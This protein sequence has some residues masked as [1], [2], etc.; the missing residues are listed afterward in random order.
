MVYFLYLRQINNKTNMK[1][2]SKFLSLCALAI[3]LTFTACK[4]DKVVELPAENLATYTGDLSYAGGANTIAETDGKATVSQSGKIVSISFN[5]GVPS[6][7]S[8]QFEKSGSNYVSIT[9][10]GSVAGISFS[11]NTVSIAYTKDGATWGFTGS[12]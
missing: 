2:I 8:V 1:T 9:K 4:K 6:I 10:D 11:G 5:Y 3:V 12:K 7:S